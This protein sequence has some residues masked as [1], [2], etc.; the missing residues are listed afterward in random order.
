MC[1]LCLRTPCHPMCP[2]APEPMALYR[3]YKC[4]TG[5][6]EGEKYL[7]SPKGQIC[8]DCLDRMRVEELLGLL[9]ES[10]TI[11]EREEM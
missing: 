11:A 4:G 7:D 2:N 6:A 10:L 5:I 1:S 3:C 8:E 9:G